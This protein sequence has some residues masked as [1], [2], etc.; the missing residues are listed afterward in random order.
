MRNVKWPLRVQTSHPTARSHGARPS[1]SQGACLE[2][3]SAH[4]LQL[5]SH[6]LLR[7]PSH[8]QHRHSIALVSDIEALMG[9]KKKIIQILSTYFN[10]N[11]NILLKKR[12]H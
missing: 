6:S 8:S 11:V 1:G 2:A 3:T 7:Q 10:R 4:S 5:S 9:R 12:S